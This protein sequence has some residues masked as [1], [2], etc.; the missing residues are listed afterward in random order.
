MEILQPMGV[1]PNGKPR[2]AYSIYRRADD[3]EIAN[4]LIRAGLLKPTISIEDIKE[5]EK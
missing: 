2:Y 4:I 3:G 1:F 5:G